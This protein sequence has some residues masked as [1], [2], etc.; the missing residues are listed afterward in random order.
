MLIGIVG[1]P[2]SGKST[3]FKASTLADVAIAPHPFTTIKPNHGI[4]FVR[5]EC[6]EKFF[7]VKCN[8][9]FGYCLSGIRFVPVDLLDV[10]GLVPGA[11]EGKGLGNQFLDD[12]RQA[13]VLIHVV[14]ISGSTN[15]NGESVDKLS[16]NPC[17]DIEFLEEE[18]NLWF[19]NILGK[20]WD[21]FVRQAKQEKREIVKAIAKQLSGLKVNEDQVE[22]SIRNLNLNKETPEAWSENNLLSLCKELRRL[23]KPIIIAANKI[24]VSGSEKYFEEAKKKFPGLLIVPCSA[25]S[26]LALKEAAKAGLID[27]IPGSMSFE[28]TDKGKK[29]LSEQQLNALNFIQK[30]ILDKYKSTGIQ[31][32]LDKAVFD[33][34]KY[35]AIFPGGMKKLQDSE[36]R[37]LPDCFLMEPGTTALQFAYKIHTTIGDT[38]VKAMDVK[39][40]MAVGKEYNL[41]SGDVIE[42]I[43]SK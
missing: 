30:N 38:F 16:Y 36:G 25:E 12:L 11:H 24:D 42:I 10:A 14:D 23:S 20:G 35:L 34:L 5:T 17:K 9:R 19:Y 3:F 26:E 7:N 1:K 33:F 39:K 6:P 15:E 43:T 18:I 21:K 22:L 37:T 13:D 2:S 29:V 31:E 4:G 28:I 41:K 32:L 40:R 8:P 27:Y